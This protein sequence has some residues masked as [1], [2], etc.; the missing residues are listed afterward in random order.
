MVRFLRPWRGSRM[1]WIDSICI[2]QDDIREREAQV[3]KMAHIYSECRQAVVY[4]GDDIVKPL[5]P[6][7]YPPRRR[8]ED[9]IGR[10]TSRGQLVNEDKREVDIFHLLKRRYFS[11]VWIIQELIL[12]RQ[13][14]IPVGTMELC[15]DKLTGPALS[16]Y[17]WNRTA[18][19][20]IQQAGQRKL[21]AN[22]SNI[23]D[24]LRATSQSKAGDPRDKVFGA[25]A[26]INSSHLERSALR[27]DYSLSC[28][29]VF[30]GVYAYSL[31]N[32]K[33]TELLCN[34][35]GVSAPDGYP[36]WTPSWRQPEAVHAWFLKRPLEWETDRERAWDPIAA[37]ERWTGE[38]FYLPKEKWAGEAFRTWWEGTGGP[39]VSSTDSIRV[40]HVTTEARRWRTSRELYLDEKILAHDW[41]REVPV[42]LFSTEA[43][44]HHASS[45]PHRQWDRHCVVDAATGSLSL[46]LVHVLPFQTAPAEAGT[47]HGA[48]IFRVPAHVG[49]ADMYL[50][51][52]DFAL[53]LHVQPGR[54]HLFLMDNGK[55]LPPF[56]L[57]MRKCSDGEAL[58]WAFRLLGCCHHLCFRANPGSWT[59]KSVRV[60]YNRYDYDRDEVIIEDEVPRRN[61]DLFLADLQP[62]SLQATVSSV[63]STVMQ[64][65][66]GEPGELEGLFLGMGDL[67]KTLPAFQGLLNERRLATP[68][69]LDSY[70]TCLDK[71]YQPRVRGGHVELV[72]QPDS[73][74]AFYTPQVKS[75]YKEWQYDGASDWSA[76]RLVRYSLF[77]SKKPIRVRAAK[78]DLEKVILES[79]IYTELSQLTR[80][81]SRA[82]DGE[83]SMILRC[84]QPEDGRT[85]DPLW[86]KSVM[87]GFNIDG[88]TYKVTIL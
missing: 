80:A 68:G 22:E 55:S 15:V 41:S 23:Y 43:S 75:L 61:E 4:L 34:A 84:D 10:S 51:T 39:S 73:W 85:A 86:P 17:N 87:E 25:H 64:S 74:Q 66:R 49:E 29:H 83:V 62:G 70:V 11:R 42:E 26:L 37:K 8:L 67:T 60:R 16:S 3:A 44:H 13:I 36:S 19:P 38:R 46:Q 47:A 58:P 33:R 57:V 54:D 35:A 12:P 77:R 56:Y 69:F 18:A 52:D 71:K 82:A 14:S 78:R 59:R 88:Y 32:L 79:P 53:D 28:L 6:G 31:I 7:E 45:R 21:S 63:R 40:M 50:T 72:V 81:A 9:A 27:P 48:K 1:V 30:F 24:I 65:L 20:W 5:S 76:S 2:N